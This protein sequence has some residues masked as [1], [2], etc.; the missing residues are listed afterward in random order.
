VPALGRAV[1]RSNQG[2]LLRRHPVR[3]H[4][5]GLPTS[6]GK[7]V[8]RLGAG[9]RLRPPPRA[10]PEQGELLGVP[11]HPDVNAGERDRRHAG[12]REGF[13]A[14]CDFGRG[15]VLLLPE[16]LAIR[17]GHC[18]Q[19]QD[20]KL[21]VQQYISAVAWP[22]ARGYLQGNGACRDKPSLCTRP[23]H[24][25][26]LLRL[27]CL[28][29]NAKVAAGGGLHHATERGETSPTRVPRNLIRG[30]TRAHWCFLPGMEDRKL[31][32]ASKRHRGEA[33]FEECVRICLHGGAR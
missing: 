6:A 13:R 21:P 14:E 9:W 26:L 31:H 8:P 15:K 19:V 22:R 5:H 17:T 27:L 29:R 1:L 3:E 33:N 7:K 24:V 2:D 20:R 16:K 32:C 23:W 28:Q 12:L 18:H 30:R 11:L 4:L 10:K 25:H